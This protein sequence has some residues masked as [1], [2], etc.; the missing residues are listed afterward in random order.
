MFPGL[1]KI[2]NHSVTKILISIES[3]NDVK[4]PFLPTSLGVAA[5]TVLLGV[6]A[7]RSQ[8]QKLSGRRT[9]A[10]RRVPVQS[11]FDHLKGGDSIEVFLDGFPSVRRE[12]VVAVLEEMEALVPTHA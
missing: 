5:G 7:S 9:R 2:S 10:S 3:K 11:L 8:R 12:Q 1:E 6:S 4:K